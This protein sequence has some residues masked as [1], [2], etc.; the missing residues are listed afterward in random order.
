MEALTN[1]SDLSIIQVAIEA[2]APLAPV[3]LFATPVDEL[4]RTLLK[5]VF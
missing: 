3:W 1:E 2:A 4:V 5:M